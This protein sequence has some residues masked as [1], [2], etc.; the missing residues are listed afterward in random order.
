MSKEPIKK[1]ILIIE[2]DR[3]MIRVLADRFLLEGFRVLEAENGEIGLELSQKEKP[4]L[5]ILDIILP[6]MD[7]ITM[8]K[9]LR[10]NNWGKDIPVIV[11]TNLSDT[12]TIIKVFKQGIYDFLVKTDW[13]IEDIVKKTKERLKIE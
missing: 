3:A 4:D 7:G 10:A 6:R 5:I 12:E 13:K 8:L 9:K 2:D 11:L 1:T